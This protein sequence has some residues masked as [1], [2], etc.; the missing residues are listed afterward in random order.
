MFAGAVAR[1][2]AA[3][4]DPSPKNL[5]IRPRRLTRRSTQVNSVVDSLREL[6]VHVKAALPM[7]RFSWYRSY[8]MNL[9]YQDK[10]HAPQCQV[11]CADLRFLATGAAHKISERTRDD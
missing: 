7:P 11:A 3:T 5:A 6:G 2:P 9:Q 4:K 10:L 8:T 1:A